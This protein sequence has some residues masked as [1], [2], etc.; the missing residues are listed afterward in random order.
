[1]QLPRGTFREIKKHTKFG[2]LFEDLQQTRFSG[3]CTISFGKVNGI[4]VFKSGKRILA[5]YENFIGDAAWDE[6]QK[7]VEET[8]DVALSTLDAA[9][10]ELSLE[11]NKSCRIQNVGKAEHPHLQTI[12][13]THPQS[14]KKPP[15]HPVKMH[16]VKQEEDA[17]V[18][19]NLIP[20]ISESTTASRSVTAESHHT[21]EPSKKGGHTH[22]AKT[23]HKHSPAVSPHSK[24]YSQREEKKEISQE[25]KSSSAETNSLDFD[26]DIQTFEPLDPEAVSNFDRDIDTFETMDLEAITNK[27]RVECK[28]IIKQLNLEHLKEER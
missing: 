6:L 12:S 24:G 13:S 16:P 3:I 10:I 26:K 15:G 22:P 18:K 28:D 20:A 21:K 5:E 2:V 19:N 14:V 11:F 9:Q 1:M 8:V 25:E 17:A 27:I 4:I 7:I 23:S